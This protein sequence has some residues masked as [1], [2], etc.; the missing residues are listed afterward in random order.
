MFQ[1][2]IA[3]AFPM[4]AS[5]IT[6]I[7]AAPSHTLPDLRAP[8]TY[9]SSF[10]IEFQLP[11]KCRRKLK[12]SS[13]DVIIAHNFAR[14]KS[15]DKK[16]T[17]PAPSEMALKLTATRKMCTIFP[18]ATSGRL[19]GAQNGGTVG[20]SCCQRIWN[21]RGG[22]WTFIRH[23]LMGYCSHMHAG[24]IWESLGLWP[25]R[26]RLTEA[27]VNSSIDLSFREKCEMG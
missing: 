20:S 10:Q 9:P 12:L 3:F 26:E 24:N 15:R 23:P 22:G 6:Q 17:N 18:L 21:Y 4:I 25:H 27:L 16:K 2:Q 7:A 8:K 19:V 5:L 1:T 13:R 11:G 14:R